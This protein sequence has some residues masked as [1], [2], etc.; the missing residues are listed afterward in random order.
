MPQTLPTP[1]RPGLRIPSTFRAL[2]HRNFRLYWTG[3][4]ISLI[5]T[6]MQSVGQGWLVYQLSGSA[7]M[8]GVVG[9]AQ[10]SPVLVL[11]PLGGILADRFPKRDLLL[12]TQ[13]AMLVLAL[14]L[15]ALTWLGVV[16]VWHVVVLALLLGVCNA[17]DAPTRQSFVV[18]MVGKADLMNAIALNSSVFNGARLIGPTL[19]ALLIGP[20]G[21]AS[22]FF[23]NA[24]AFL[25][26]IVNLLRMKLAPFEKPK[27][28]SPWD[29]LK[30][31]FSYLRSNR[32][33]RALLSLVG[34][35]SLCGAPYVTLLPA[36]AAQ[37]LGSDASGYGFL[38]AGV[39]TGGLIAALTLASG[40]AERRK[41]RTLLAGSFTF[42][43]LLI[44]FSLSG[45]YWLSWISLIGVGWGFL[46][47][48]ASTNT[49]VQTLAPDALRGRVMSA[50][51]WVL[52]GLFPVGSLLAGALASWW[53]PDRA[54]LIGAVLLLAYTGWMYVNRP[55]I[56]SL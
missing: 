32:E 52:M 49:L 20:L 16:Q 22:L 35:S 1:L 44:A 53:G 26:I 45:W 34:I 8:L 11:S 23:L 40:R 39:A 56:R 36:Y 5:G 25:A 43:L 18:E 46:T 30:E 6:F 3:Q 4:L 14:G 7:L 38:M 41:G 54:I 19:A 51:A 10:F 12:L 2:R 48:N 47:Q 37:V 21:I 17:L 28:T 50:Y 13:S 15:G 24:L 31:G 9:F 55:Q 33:I 27:K 29:S 42:A